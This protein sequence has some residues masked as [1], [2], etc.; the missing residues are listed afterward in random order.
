MQPT[1]ESSNETITLPVSAVTETQLNRLAEQVES[2]PSRVAAFLLDMG[3]RHLTR[4][5]KTADA[6]FSA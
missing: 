5:S 4:T 2:D 3:V 6:I 1:Q